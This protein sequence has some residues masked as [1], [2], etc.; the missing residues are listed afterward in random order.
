M[1]K[2]IYLRNIRMVKHTKIIQYNMEQNEGEK[3]KH[4]NQYEEVF[5]KT[6]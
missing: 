4:P 1:I 3:Y 2:R 5:D 6:Q